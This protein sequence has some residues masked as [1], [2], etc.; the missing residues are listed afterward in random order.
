MIYTIDYIR[1]EATAIASAWNGSD[2][3]FSHEGEIF[4]DDDAQNAVELINKLREVEEL[5]QSLNI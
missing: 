3:K 1:K 5:M 4:T 2:E